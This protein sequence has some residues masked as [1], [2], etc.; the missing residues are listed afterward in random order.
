MESVVCRKCQ[1]ENQAGRRFCGGCG[2]SLWQ[3][4]P[5]CGAECPADER[6]CGVCGSDVAN[7]LEELRRDC[8]ARFDSAHDLAKAHQYPAAIVALRAV[9]MVADPRLQPFA[10]RAASEI[11]SLD[12]LSK[13]EAAK[14]QQTFHN[15]QAL[16]AAHDYEASQQ[17][18]E[19]I[20]EP[21]RTGEQNDFLANLIAIQQELR[22]L[23]RELRVALEEKRTGDVLPR[24]ERLLVL[25]PA[26]TQGLKLAGQLRDRAVIAAKEKHQAHN[27]QKAAEHLQQI[28]SVA[29]TPDIE[30]FRDK[31]DELASLMS[32][33]RNGALADP[34]LLSLAERLCKSAPGNTAA[35]HLRNQMAERCQSKP[36][37][38]RLGA[39]NWAPLPPRTLLGASVDWLA[40]FQRLKGT[41]DAVTNTLRKYPGQFFTAVGLALQGVGLAAIDAHLTPQPDKAGVFGQLPSFSFSRQPT[42]AAWGIDLSSS[43]VKAIKL[44]R[45]TKDEVRIEAAEYLELGNAASGDNS[46][47][48]RSNRLNAWLSE[49]SSRNRDSKGIKFCIGIPGQQVLGRFFELPPMPARK[50]TDAIQYEARHQLPIDLTELCWSHSVLNE[51]RDQKSVP[52]KDQPKRIFVQAAR[53]FHVRN[54]IGLFKA[55]GIPV[56]LVQSDYVAL[57]NAAV[58]ELKRETQKPDAPQAAVALLDVGSDGTNLVISSPQHLW[59]RTFNPGGDTFIRELVQE[60]RS[61]Y[62]QA[63]RM[64]RDPARVRRFDRWCGALH[65]LYVQLGSETLRSIASC[66]KLWS[67]CHVGQVYG[68]GGAFQTLGLLR[69]L[70]SGQ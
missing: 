33:V 12:R 57:H 38:H 44:T 58:Y 55:A 4:C 10:T 62:E 43:A 11:E 24:L 18:L 26:H 63:H 54:K 3:K 68:V 2:G 27:Y 21:L 70:R 39:A 32:E 53:D 13:S 64:L 49:F 69:Y 20:P 31:I 8:E 66:Q 9:A 7:S 45:D 16:L 61:T 35:E 67:D 37:D 22:E 60:F 14:A 50:F 42:N 34:G 5:R 29:M 19:Q 65:P 52:P 25:K 41:S 23:M 47:E 40:H 46:D 59:F 51:A 56:D 30:D 6:F 48:L 15:A 28:P 1:R 36:A 17:T